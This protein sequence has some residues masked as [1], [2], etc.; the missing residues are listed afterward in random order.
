MLPRI[1]NPQEIH[2]EEGTC[3]PGSLGLTDR[4]GLPRQ[5]QS[6]DM[7]WPLAVLSW[8]GF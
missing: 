4:F 6:R 8:D 5:F 7:Q 1:S 3:K 2:E